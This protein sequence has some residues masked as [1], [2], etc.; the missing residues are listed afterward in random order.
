MIKK[1]INI[2]IK[3][4]SGAVL[5]FLIGCAFIHF[6]PASWDSGACSGGYKTYIYHKYIDELASFYAENHQEYTSIKAGSDYEVNWKGRKLFI[7]AELDVVDKNG[8]QDTIDAEFTGKRYWTEK[9][10]WSV[11]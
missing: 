8:K 2:F 11:L 3:L 1:C 7:T 5:I 4:L 10:T 9:F 6:A